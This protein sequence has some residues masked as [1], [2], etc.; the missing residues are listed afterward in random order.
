MRWRDPSLDELVTDE[1]ILSVGSE[2]DLRHRVDFMLE[3]LGC[4][5]F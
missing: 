1:L 4:L 3:K 5:R 2:T